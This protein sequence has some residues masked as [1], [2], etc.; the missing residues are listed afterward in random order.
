MPT[1]AQQRRKKL[2]PQPNMKEFLIALLIV[3]VIAFFVFYPIAVIWSLNTLFGF[4][5]PFT[6]STW[7]AAGLLVGVF[8]ARITIKK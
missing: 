4:T 5:I 1:A 7:C 2:Q 3:L 6:F 8:T